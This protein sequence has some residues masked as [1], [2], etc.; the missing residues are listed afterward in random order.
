MVDGMERLEGGTQLE[1]DE[2]IDRRWKRTEPLAD[3]L[4]DLRNDPEDEGGYNAI[5]DHLVEEPKDAFQLFHQVMD[6][7][8]KPSDAEIKFN[9]IPLMT[10]A[11]LV[12]RMAERVNK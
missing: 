8:P 4:G 2:E 9:S 1:S 10:I 11:N 7:Y 12:A 3:M 6:Q 5:I